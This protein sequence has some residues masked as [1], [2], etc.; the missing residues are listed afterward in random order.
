VEKIAY[1][2]TDDCIYDDVPMGSA[3]HGKEEL[4]ASWSSFFPTCPDFKIDVK[5]LF[6]AGDWAGSEWVLSGTQAADWPGMPNTG[7]SFSIVGASIME[8][9]GG[10]VKRNSDYWDMVSMLTQLG[11]MPGSS[12]E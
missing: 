10:K 4:K 11:V 2:F 5:A 7:R 9:Q 6:A 1:Y 8:L 3:T 12:S